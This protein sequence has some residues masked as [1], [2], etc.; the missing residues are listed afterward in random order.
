MALYE[1]LCFIDILKPINDELEKGVL[2]IDGKT[3]KI[4]QKWVTNP[5]HPWIHAKR[6]DSGRRCL[7]WLNTYTKYYKFVPRHCYGCWKICMRPRTFKE[8]VACLELWKKHEIQGKA[9][10]EERSYGGAIWGAFVYTPLGEGLD[11]GRK[12]WAKINRL[13]KENVSSSLK[14]FLKR[15]CTEMELMKGNS[16]KWEY[17]KQHQL[18][19]DLLDAAFEED[20]F[21][22]EGFPAMLEVHIMRR[23]IEHAAKIGDLTYLKYVDKP[24]IHAAVNYQ[25]SIHK[26]EDLLIPA[27]MDIEAGDYK[28]GTDNSTIGGED[29]SD[30]ND[31]QKLSIV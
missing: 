8:T 29:D 6:D 26:A 14:V 30:N 16:D 9:G 19:E 10:I 31:E 23:W 20:P 25:K 18:L 1:E 28:D 15:G 17:T 27:R 11:V 12:L 13:V 3:W 21:E 7:R 4:C 2:W 5:N 22:P 24:L